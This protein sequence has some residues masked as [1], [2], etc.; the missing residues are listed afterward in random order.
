MIAEIEGSGSDP[1]PEGEEVDPD[2]P[3]EIES[4]DPA[5]GEAA[6]Q[7]LV[8]TILSRI[9]RDPIGNSLSIAMLVV[10]LAS[11]VVLPVRLGRHG[12]ADAPGWGVPLLLILGLGIAGY[13]AFVETTG[14]EAVCGPVGDCNTVQ[15]S[16]YAVLFGVLPV[17]VS[18]ILGYLLLLGAWIL[19]RIGDSRAANAAGFVL[20]PLALFG[21]VFSIYLTFLEPF[22]I[23]ASCAWCLGSALIMTLL[24]WLVTKPSKAAWRRLTRPAR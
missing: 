20:L 15:S 14:S 7:T 21:V 16:S 11:V 13:L 23:G 24:L 22:V 17:G 1:A 10:M 2:P 19:S 4:A 12:R 18:G 8:A 3:G 5:E 9:G 6:E